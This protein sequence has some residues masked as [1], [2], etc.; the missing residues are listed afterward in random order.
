MNLP[1]SVIAAIS[2]GHH[3]DAVVRQAANVAICLE[4]G[5]RLLHVDSPAHR[6]PDSKSRDRLESA[7]LGACDVGAPCDTEV[8]SG[9]P[10][11]V[12]VETLEEDDLLV[13]G[14]GPEACD[15]DHLSG[16][17]AAVV[18]ETCRPI[19]VLLHNGNDHLVCAV[20]GDSCDCQ[21]QAAT[22]IASRLGLPVKVI[23][24]RPAQASRKLPC[25]CYYG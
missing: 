24:E 19:L 4:T 7:R 22:A 8:L 16:I 11:Q 18:W 17:S 3:P 15:I 21:H 1:K 23:H 25:E 9:E 14:G 6:Q 5:L 12:L 2:F 10:L 20:A 13:M